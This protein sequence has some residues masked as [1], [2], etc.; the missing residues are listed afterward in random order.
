M[1]TTNPAEQLPRVKIAPGKP[2]PAGE[3]AIYAA[4]KAAPARVRLMIRLGAELGLRSCEIARIHSKDIEN[5]LLGYTLIV[6]GKGGKIRRVP[7]SNDIAKVI[8]HANGWLF[9]GKIDGHLSGAHVSKLI[10]RAL[11]DGVTA[12][13]LR[14][15]AAGQ[16]YRATSHD[17]RAVQELLGHASVATT[18]IYTPADNN[19]LRLAVAGARL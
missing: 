9:T 14:H 16:F 4:L 17:I 13:M 15:R 2:R 1:I 11:P 6:H 18:Q 10:S 19:Q 8:Q 7:C 3:V 5:D 12:H